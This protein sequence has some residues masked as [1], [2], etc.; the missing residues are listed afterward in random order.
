MNKEQR[1]QISKLRCEG[2]SYSKISEL[3]GLSI[4]TIK[5][6]CRRNNLGGIGT[7][8]NNKSYSFC[9]KCGKQLEIMPKSKP[10]KFCSDNCR[11]TWWNAHSENV[12]R[13]AVYNFTC[14]YCGIEFES[15]GNSRRK[16]C[17]R[18]C[19]GKHKS[20]AVKL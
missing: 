4:N 3:L 19:Y 5:S 9:H 2:V 6:F 13:K 7:N 1:E 20:M 18:F 8:A 16:F 14:G 17:N 11:M 10:R 15:Y 12:N